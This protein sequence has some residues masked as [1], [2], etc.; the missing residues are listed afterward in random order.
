MVKE[1]CSVFGG[2]FQAVR[3]STAELRAT[4]PDESSVCTVRVP[5]DKTVLVCAVMHEPIVPIGVGQVD[6]VL[7][8]DFE[9]MCILHFSSWRELQ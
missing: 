8:V 4:G 3:F 6:V 1:V 9:T 5:T 7:V 2:E